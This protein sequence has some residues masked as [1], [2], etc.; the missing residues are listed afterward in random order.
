MIL[1]RIPAVVRIEDAVY[2][3]NCECL[4]ETK[5]SAGECHHCKSKAIVSL[6]GWL[7]RTEVGDGL[8]RS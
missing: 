4:T 1:D 3:E 2:C 8:Q 5:F 7:N 6:S